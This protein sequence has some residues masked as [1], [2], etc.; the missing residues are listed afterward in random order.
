MDI[1]VGRKMVV[2]HSRS[3]SSKVVSNDAKNIY[4]SPLKH[5]D[6][7]SCL[8]DFPELNI[9]FTKISSVILLLQSEKTEVVQ[10]VED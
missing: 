1:D 5:S 4:K 8:T 10:E 2:K 7:N 9:K 3:L 6:R